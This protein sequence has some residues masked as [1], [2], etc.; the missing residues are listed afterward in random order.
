[1]TSRS[2]GVRRLGGFLTVLLTEYWSGFTLYSSASSVRF[3]WPSINAISGCIPISMR[4]FTVTSPTAIKAPWF[5]GS[6][7]SIAERATSGASSGPS[8]N[9]P[10][11]VLNSSSN[12]VGI[13]SVFPLSDGGIQGCPSVSTRPFRILLEERIPPSSSIM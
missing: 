8:N 12:S 10:I 7:S 9:S 3:V 4:P 1:M 2:S 13:L 5:A 11:G 6:D